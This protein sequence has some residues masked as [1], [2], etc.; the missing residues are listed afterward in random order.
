MLPPPPLWTPRAPFGNQTPGVSGQ[1]CKALPGVV[2]SSC[3]HL[4]GGLYPGCTLPYRYSRGPRRQN[5]CTNLLPSTGA[6]AMNGYW[7]FC[8]SRAACSRPSRTTRPQ[9]RRLRPSVCECSCLEVKERLESRRKQGDGSERQEAASSACSPQTPAPPC[10]AQ[11][12]GANNVAAARPAAPP[13]GVASGHSRS[14]RRCPLPP[15]RTACLS[16]PALFF[17]IAQ[18]RD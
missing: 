9:A 17:S 16:R 14:R 15:S 12:A 6:I 11:V 8:A 1:P 4:P 2:R 10:C 3:A 7:R 18:V 13:T 5:S